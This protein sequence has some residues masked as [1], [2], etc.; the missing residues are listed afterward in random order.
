MA[1]AKKPHGR[2]SAY[3]DEIAAEIVRRLSTGEPLAVICRDDG[4]P[5]D[6]T[7][8]NWASAREGFSRDIARARDAG[9]DAIAMRARE[10]ARGQGD[11]RGDVQ[12]DKLIIETDLKLLAKW[13]PKKYG[14]KVALTGGSEDDAPIKTA[15]TVTFV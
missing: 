13:N 15:L 6:D 10:T 11:S 12:R 2:P 3:T 9:H 4:F 14:D 1:K 7:V 8:R 5:S